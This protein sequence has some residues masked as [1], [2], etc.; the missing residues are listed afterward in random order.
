MASDEEYYQGDEEGE[1]LDF[2]QPRSARERLHPAF[3]MLLEDDGFVAARGIVG[4]MMHW[5]EDPDGNFIEQFQTVAFDARLWE[6]YLFAAFVEMG[7]EINRIHAVPDFTCR[8]R[9]GEFAVEAVTINPSRDSA[10]AVVPPPRI[11]TPE[12]LQEFEHQ[13]M[14][15]RFGR[16]LTNKLAKKYWT[17]PNVSGKPLL[18]AI[19]D[20]SAPR[21]MLYSRSALPIYLYGYRHQ[22]HH[23]ERGRL[24]ITPQKMGLRGNLWA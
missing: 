11:E 10:G 3:L 6:L 14:P 21:S 5:Y 24:H 12:E 9:R 15:L 4:P 19:Q 18:F 1:P 16:S 17:R 23:D 20:F 22:W 13:Y 8:G 7:C 2:F